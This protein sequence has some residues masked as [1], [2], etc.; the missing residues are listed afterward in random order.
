MGTGDSPK[1]D[2]KD[3][4]LLSSRA[5]PETDSDNPRAG[6]CWEDASVDGGQPPYSQSDNWLPADTHPDI[7]LP[8]QAESQAKLS[9]HK[10]RQSGKQ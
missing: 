4:G 5:P 9:E 7:C 10:Q 6:D 3:T 1:E 2:A 8:W